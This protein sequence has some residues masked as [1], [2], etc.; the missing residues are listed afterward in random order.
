[1]TDNSRRVTLSNGTMKRLGK[2]A[3]PFESPE[4]CIKRI[5]NCDCVQEEM[6]KPVT[7]DKKNEDDVTDNEME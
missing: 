1:M 4:D 6:K 2:F 3:K 5:V 7:N